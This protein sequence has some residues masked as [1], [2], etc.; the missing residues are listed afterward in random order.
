MPREVIVFVTG[1]EFYAYHGVPDAEQAIG[2]RYRLD[3]EMKVVCGATE[4]DRVEETV[5]YGEVSALLVRTATG[6]Q[7]RTVE[8]LANLMLDELFARFPSINS[9]RI[10]LAKRLPPAPLIVDEL[11]VQIIRDR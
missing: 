4:S 9:A 11:G 10:R 3:L 5:D 1:L 2:H 7:V 6:Q 8:R